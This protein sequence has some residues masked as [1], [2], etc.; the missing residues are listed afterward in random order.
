ME[1][2]QR[3][4]LVL[5]KLIIFLMFLCGI[6][7]LIIKIK[8]NWYLLES[9]KSIETNKV[10]NK[11]K[12]RTNGF[13]LKNYE[14]KFE[15]LKTEK[16]EVPQKGVF[17]KGITSKTEKTEEIKKKEKKVKSKKG[18]YYIQIGTYSNK[19]NAEVKKKELEKY[20]AE[21][22]KMKMKDKYYYRVIINGIT[23]KEEAQAMI[24]QINSKEKFLIRVR[25]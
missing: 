8:L 11:L 20:N 22:T 21:I 3:N 2:R 19:K 9:K 1:R 6:M 14:F 10:I 23:N 16:T 4:K 15:K 12:I 13:Y 7:N 25:Y 24:S 18:N 17:K 5:A